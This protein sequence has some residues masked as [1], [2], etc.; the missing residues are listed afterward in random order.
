MG[1]EGGRAPAAG[2]RARVS[3][4]EALAGFL[5]AAGGAPQVTVLHA[6][7]LPALPALAARLPARQGRTV[8]Q[9]ERVGASRAGLGVKRQ[10]TLWG[11]LQVGLRH[12]QDTAR[13]SRSASTIL[14]LCIY[15][16]VHLP[17]CVAVN[18]THTSEKPQEGASLFQGSTCVLASQTSSILVKGALD[19]E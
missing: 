6:V 19:L 16:H 17:I 7:H 14:S 5:P 13:L 2:P 12:V 18:Y 10:G 15:G 9:R 1:G 11:F 8:T 4:G 3:V